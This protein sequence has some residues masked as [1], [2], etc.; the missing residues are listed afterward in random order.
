MPT[1]R[2]CYETDHQH[3]WSN[4]AQMEIW[5]KTK[6]L[7]RFEIKQHLHFPSNAKFYSVFFETA[8]VFEYSGAS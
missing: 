2:E 8:K 1:I 5:N 3:C 7:G 6:A 4:V